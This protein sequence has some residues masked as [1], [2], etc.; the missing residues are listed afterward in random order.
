MR[1]WLSNC[2]FYEV[3]PQSFKDSNADGIGDIPGIIEKLD[4]I[5]EMGFRGIWLNPCFK[6][7]FMDAG[8]DVEDFYTGIIKQGRER[9]GHGDCAFLCPVGQFK[10]GTYGF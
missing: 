2:V 9:R 1:T 6:S 8:Y 7:P 10:G 4:Y 3:Y 5:A